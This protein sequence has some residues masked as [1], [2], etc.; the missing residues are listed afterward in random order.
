MGFQ[1]T[2][3]AGSNPQLFPGIVVNDSVTT[4]PLAG[5]VNDLNVSGMAL[6][7]TIKLTASS[8]FTLTGIVGGTSGMQRRLENLSAF[9]GAIS[10]NTGSIASNQFAAAGSIPAG[11]FLDIVYSATL[12]KWVTA[13]TSGGSSASGVTSVGLSAPSIFTVTNSPVTTTG[14]LTFT[15]A[16]AQGDII[17]ASASNTLVALAK[18]A[19]ATRYL[20]NTGVTNNPAWAQINLAN[21]VT[22]N[23]PVG[24]LNSGTAASGTT[25]WRG[26]ATWATPPA[27]GTVAGADTQMQFN[28]AAAFGATAGFTFT[29]GTNTITVGVLAT[30][31]T[32]KTPDATG[33]TLASASM[34][35]TTGLG[36]ATSGASGGLTISTGTAVG[37][38]SGNILIRPGSSQSSAGGITVSGGTG[39]SG[40]NGGNASLSG[41]NGIGTNAAGGTGNVIGGDSA[42]TSTG[43]IANVRG[44]TGG[45]T[46]A[47]GSVVL[48]AGSGGGTSGDAGDISLV[49]G[50][51]VSGNPSSLLLTGLAT[52]GAQ[53]ATFIATNKPGS[54]TGAPTNWLRAKVGSTIFWIPMFAN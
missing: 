1:V 34:T 25:F 47:G 52:T 43:G 53:T 5:N 49:A 17:Y 6:V 3:G 26:D 27:G 35:V 12:S 38:N 16:G 37:S 7:T 30:A 10:A 54:A 2:S 13:T 15:Y 33:A 14:T 36:G 45:A 40:A 50:S 29:K 18:D 24:N 28:D 32:I 4:D 8:S 46:G 39:L 51:V 22:G 42:G 19:N 20:S 11:Q 9:T 41:G 48:T 21:G 31:P 44:G 23:L